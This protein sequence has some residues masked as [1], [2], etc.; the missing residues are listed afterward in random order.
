MKMQNEIEITK[1]LGQLALC[2]D[3]QLEPA[4]VALY[5]F[6]L[7]DLD[8]NALRVAVQQ[9][10]RFGHSFPFP[11]ELRQS[12]ESKSPTSIFSTGSES[13]TPKLAP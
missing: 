6:L 11:A 1:L 4:K 7:R 3:Y 10:L 2:L 13:E 5:V 9:H 8:I 12:A